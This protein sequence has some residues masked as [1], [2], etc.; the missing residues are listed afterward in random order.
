M[1]R[2][3]TYEEEINGVKA[4]LACVPLLKEG[5]FSGG[6]V[7]EKKGPNKCPPK[8]CKYPTLFKRVPK[9]NDQLVEFYD[10]AN[11]DYCNKTDDCD[12]CTTSCF[13]KCPVRATCLPVT[14]RRKVEG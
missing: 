4:T 12:N 10:A 8:T 9:M 6:A 14:R 11:W 1:F 3:P 7:V 13:F 5:G 2:P